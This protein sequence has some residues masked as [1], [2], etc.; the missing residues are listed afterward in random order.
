MATYTAN[1]VADTLIALAREQNIEISNLKLQKLLYYAQAW[2]LVLREA[3][4]FRE[5][6]EAWVHGPVVPEVFRRF[7]SY[8]WQPITEN[9]T[10]LKDVEL[11]HHLLAVLEVYGSLKPTQLE[12]LSHSERPWKDARGN[13]DPIAASNEV[14]TQQSMKDFFSE[15]YEA[16]A[17][18]TT[19]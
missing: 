7:K 8:R 4:L 13:L 16:N 12:R 17:Q 19:A 6:F 14:I 2:S 1:E 10:P 3:P 11:R 5:D 15:L 9:V 18:A